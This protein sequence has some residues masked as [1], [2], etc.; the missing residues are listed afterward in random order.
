MLLLSLML[1]ALEDPAAVK[2]DA[3]C[4]AV[5]LAARDSLG[6]DAKGEGAAAAA[7]AA[8]YVGKLE[9][10]YATVPPMAFA[11]ITPF[12]LTRNAV[13]DADRKL[14]GLDQA[15]VVSSARA[16]FEAYDRMIAAL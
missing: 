14:R 5:L 1:V 9:G 7:A 3:K 16:C 8:Y 10:Y 2:Q 12:E 4:A 13:V 11:P 6:D 15:S